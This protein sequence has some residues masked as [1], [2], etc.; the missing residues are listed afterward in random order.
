MQ[1][2]FQADADLREVIIKA[3]LRQEPTIDITSAHQANLIGLNDNQVLAVAADEG[4]VLV[5]HDRKTMPYHF[6]EF[7]N[8][9]TSPG[10]IVV[11]QDLAVASAVEE[12]L[13]VWVTSDASEWLNRICYLP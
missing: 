7:I 11:P 6:A 2:R 13:L 5:T 12:L 9:R 1:I 10:V 3:L 8:E 4:R